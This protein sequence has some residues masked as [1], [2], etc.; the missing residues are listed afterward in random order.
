MICGFFEFFFFNEII[1]VI[2]CGIG[3]PRMQTVG[4]HKMLFH[5]MFGIAAVI[6]T[7]V[8]LD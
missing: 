7:V 1:R 8:S 6:D 4:E 2:Y 3:Y 5:G